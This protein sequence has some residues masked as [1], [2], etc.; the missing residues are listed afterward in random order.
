[1]CL[2]RLHL[3][4]GLCVSIPIALWL[5]AVMAGAAPAETA[6][7]I[8]TIADRYA[9][10]TFSFEVS[11]ETGRAGIRLEYDY[12]PA[13]TGGYDGNWD[14]SPRIALLPGLTYDTSAHAIVYND[15]AAH[16]TCATEVGHTVVFWKTVHMKPTGSCRVSARVTHHAESD[17]WSTHRYNTLDTWFEV[18]HK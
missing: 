8:D 14:P 5:T 11:P 1:M 15:G 9:L 18:R 16:T 10:H 4:T 2:E 6:I 13:R 17:G 12:P 7:V 3:I